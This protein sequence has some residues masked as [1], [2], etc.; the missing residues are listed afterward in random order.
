[1]RSF[2]ECLAFHLFE[3]R[4]RPNCK[5]K[6]WEKD[7][8]A[9]AVGRASGRAVGNWLNDKFVPARIDDFEEA[10]FGNNDVE[11]YA[12]WRAEFRAAHRAVSLRKGSNRSPSPLWDGCPYPGL[13]RFEP[14]EAAIF[15]GRER[16]AKSLADLLADPAV[17]FIAV[18]GASGTGKSSLVSAGALPALTE[19]G[20]RWPV[21]SFAPGYAGENPF[22]A[23]SFELAK[24]LVRPIKP[25]ELAQTLASEPDSFEQIAREVLER[26]PPDSALV[27]FVDQFEELFKES[28]DRHKKSFINLIYAAADVGYLRTIVTL[29]DDFYGAFANQPLLVELL[30]DKRSTFPI[31][32]P[33]YSALEK[34]IRG[35]AAR[36]GLVL[37]DGVVEQLLEDAGPDPGEA[38]PLI[39]FCLEELYRRTNPRKQIGELDYSEI[40][41]LRGAIGRRLNEILT[42][43]SIDRDELTNSLE[44]IFPLIVHVDITGKTVRRW[45]RRRAFAQPA[46]VSKIVEQL[47]EKGLLHARRRETDEV[48]TLRHEALIQEWSELQNWIQHKGS[49]FRRMHSLLPLLASPEDKRHAIQSLVA[50]SVAHGSLI[51]PT[52]TDYLSHA[53][54]TGRQAAAEA[55]GKIGPAAAAAVPALLETLSNANEDVQRAAVLALRLIDPA[56]ATASP[57]V[58]EALREGHDP[59]GPALVEIG[60]TADEEV[61]TLVKTP[62]HNENIS[63]NI[64]RSIAGDLLYGKDPAV[65]FRELIQNALDACDAVDIKSPQNA[66]VERPI[67]IRVE[68][69]ESTTQISIRDYGIGMSRHIL[70]MVLTDFGKSLW[71]NFNTAKLADIDLADSI[72]KGLRPRGRFGIGFFSLFMIAKDVD[73]LTRAHG[74][75]ETLL[76]KFPSGLEGTPSLV[77]ELVG[78]SEI[79]EPCGTEV[80]FTLRDDLHDYTFSLI[81]QRP[82]KIYEAVKDLE[83]FADHIELICPLVSKEIV[84]TV[85][86]VEKSIP[87]LTLNDLRH[88]I[89]LYD[90]RVLGSRAKDKQT[91]PSVRFLFDNLQLMHDSQGRELGLVSLNIA[92]ERVPDEAFARGVVVDGGLRVGTMPSFFGIAQGR[93]IK[94]DRLAANTDLCLA[95]TESKQA[96][97]EHYKLN[98]GIKNGKCNLRIINGEFRTS[99]IAI[100]SELLCQDPDF[101]LALAFK[102]GGN[103]PMFDRI[104]RWIKKYVKYGKLLFY[105]Q[106]GL[107]ARPSLIWSYCYQVDNLSVLGKPSLLATEFQYE[108]DDQTSIAGMI[109]KLLSKAVNYQVRYEFGRFPIGVRDNLPLGAYAIRYGPQQ[110]EGSLTENVMD[111]MW[112]F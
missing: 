65:P 110:Q 56:T 83:L 88:D 100:V 68:N 90:R 84:C 26:H 30:Q 82:F 25:S 15:F 62:L 45:V 31:G 33:S 85:D 89:N 42:G 106:I 54:E 96:L 27:L 11:P 8:F 44:H 74:S 104:D 38:L 67:Y 34:M 35:P 97:I 41:R 76:L 19:R 92:Q 58:P 105:T 37:D 70:T 101:W 23:L 18:I 47:I 79:I 21:L 61:P 40:G 10:L 12:T 98:L 32:A 111:K 107:D 24:Q 80:S 64:I 91:N 75:A 93:I 48:V 109:A 1:M 14:H 51:V 55:L 16:E 78:G 49:F 2:G 112:R 59:A 7:E 69:S 94:A 36:A 28:A 9:N 103:A 46:A 39:A 53:P 50:E 6:R 86:S 5:W 77:T 108:L 17:G 66:G 20:H 43:R 13:R 72:K 60:R 99:R 57:V 22:L 4:T 3:N 29:R 63:W 73:I 81:T 87:A 71:R 95:S 52:L 102:K